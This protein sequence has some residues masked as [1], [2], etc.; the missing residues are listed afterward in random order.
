[1]GRMVEQIAVV[2]VIVMVLSEIMGGVVGLRIMLEKQECL[3]HK[4]EH[5]ATVRASFVVVKVHG[6][7]Q[8]MS[9]GADLVVTGPAGEQIRD[10]RDKTSEMFEFVANKEGVYRFCFTNKSP[11]YETIDFDV[12][13]SYFF[14]FDQEHAKDEHFKPL[15]ESIAKLQDALY[16]VQYEQHWLWAQTSR[17]AIVNE[18]M[19]KRAIYK[20]VFESAALVS[21]S[22]LQVYLLRRL[23]KRRLEMSGF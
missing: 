8:S 20:A 18:K 17:Q 19:G 22:G 10:F 4:A 12:H 23:F 9:S 5:G 7:R 6:W 15:L 14:H 11:F 21:A 2:A 1:M 3:S 16:N 13:S